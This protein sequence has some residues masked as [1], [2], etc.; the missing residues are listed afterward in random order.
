MLGLGTRYRLNA[1][2]PILIVGRSILAKERTLLPDDLFDRP[3]IDHGSEWSVLHTRPR[4]EKALAR[5][6]CVSDTP[7]FLPLFCRTSRK[8]RRTITSW[9]PLF[10]GYIFCLADRDQLEQAFRTN[11]VA[12]RLEVQDQAQLAQDLQRIHN[13]V[14]SG[15]SMAPE[16]RI[17]S[18]MAAE[19]IGGP[20]KGHR[21]T[22]L[23]RGTGL[24]FVLEVDFLQQGASVE[25][26]GSLIRQIY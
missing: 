8:Q 14:E 13:L 5:Q 25:V 26:D 10:P 9:L 12:N 6:F 24:R 17:E 2:Q 11:L 4:A 7:Y 23:R 22:V 21:G 3:P 19:I 20:L 18:G 16:A 15:V 1:D